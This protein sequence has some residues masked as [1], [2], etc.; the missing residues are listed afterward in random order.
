[1]NFKGENMFKCCLCGKEY[2]TEELA[3]KC[4]NKCGREG[5]SN[6]AFKVKD[7]VYSLGADETSFD[8]QCSSNSIIKDDIINFFSVLK[9]VDIPLGEMNSFEKGVLS[10]WD[11]KTEKERLND[12][13]RVKTMVNMLTS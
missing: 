5:V 11:N 6:G 10:N 7:S 4:L 8:N 9:K 1:M 12:Y 3:V 2:Q 13:N